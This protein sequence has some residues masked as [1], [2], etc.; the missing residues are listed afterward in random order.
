[1]A[2]VAY[3]LTGGLDAQQLAQIRH[4]ALLTLET[5]GVDVD[6]EDIR[7]HLSDFEGVTIRGKRVHYSGALV[8]AWIKR[9]PENNLEYSY[10]RKS[11]EFRMVGPYMPRWFIDPDS[12]ERRYGTPE[13]LAVAAQ[14]MDAYRAY[15]PSPIHV[16][17]VRPGLRQLATFKTCVLNSA[18][19][20]G[21]ANP[22]NPEDAEYLC[23]IGQASGRPPPYG[24]M[25]IP[26]S[27]LKLNHHAL[28]IIFDRRD[29]PDQFTGLVYGGGSVPMAG[30]SAP[31]EITACMAQGLAEALSAYITPKLVDE[32]VQ[33][34]CSFGGFLF[35][36]KTM[37]TGMFFPESV[38]YHAGQRQVI[39]YVLGETM[40][41]SF[42]CAALESPGDVFR[43]GFQAA[44]AALAGARS[45]LGAGAAGDESF[46]PRVFV[47]DADI[48]RHVEKFVQGLDIAETEQA[49]LDVIAH[50]ATSGMY[51]DHPSSL[52]YR[53][54]YLEPE[55]VFK[56]DN[57]D[58]LFD[59]AREKVK[60]VL[61]DHHFELPA[62]ARK[63]VD[64]VYAAAVKEAA[65]GS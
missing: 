62:D 28:R 11:G 39:E 42:R 56:Y 13:D 61:H 45:F 22:A 26:I 33:G 50:G 34:Y 35:D 2:R 32:R 54:A 15:G 7:K 48:V 30:A 21:F 6:D 36:M 60:Q 53:T 29:R 58:D 59:A 18:E 17:T 51:L 43:A 12:G 41:S 5:V 14:L 52:D 10:N 44:I 40:G 23:R 25:E 38:T 3:R 57:R 49:T 8:E 63:D 4:E 9:I 1:M 19:L 65:H 24:C 16:Q 31:I 37:D 20:G 55:L 46:D 64:A 27:P 47:L